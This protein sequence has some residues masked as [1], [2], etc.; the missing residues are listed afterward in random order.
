[1]Q[2]ERESQQGGLFD[3]M[4]A[5]GGS[6]AVI[7]EPVLPSVLAWTE[8]ERLQREKEML[9]FFISG[10]P[11]D[12]YREEMTLFDGV[13]TSNLKEHRDQKVEVACVV[14]EVARQIS[15]RDGAEWGRITVEDFHGTATVLAFGD[16]WANN[17]ESLVKDAPVLLRGGVS[18]RERDEEDPPIFLDGVVSLDAVREGGQI[19]LCIELGS[20]GCDAARLDAAKKLFVGHPGNAPVIVLWRNGGSGSGEDSPRLRSRTLRITP[21]A[22]LV[23]ELREQLGEDAVKLVKA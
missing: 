6:N 17:R 1:M 7:Q 14:T 20:G 22:E 9:G 23:A 19:G 10:H 13:N 11:L 3:M 12:K 5:D 4:Q 15:K 8:S 18:G 16:A 21:R 2:R